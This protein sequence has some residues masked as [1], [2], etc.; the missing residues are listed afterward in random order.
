MRAAGGADTPPRNGE[1]DH[2]QGGG[3]GSPPPRAVVVRARQLRRSMT[4]PEVLLW[5]QLRLR[6][7]GQKFRRQHPVGPYV[8]D[9]YCAA[10]RLIVEVE[11]W[12]HDTAQARNDMH[13]FN[14]M[15][16][17]GYRV[18]RVSAKRILA[19]V[20]GTADAIAARAESPLHHPAG[21]PPPRTG[22]ER[23]H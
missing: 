5:Q 15:A 8:A 14:F 2:P 19:D 13:R 11:G 1:G 21:G 4:T 18:L 23:Q 9:F 3:G 6:P 12:V 7:R 10:A 22:E 16:E 17:N 20:A